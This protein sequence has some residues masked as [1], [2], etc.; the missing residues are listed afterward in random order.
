MFF[1][2]NK[3]RFQHNFLLSEIFFLG[4]IKHFFSFYI[5]LTDISSPMRIEI[6][7]TKN[8]THSFGDTAH[9][10]T[11]SVTFGSELTKIRV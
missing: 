4:Y 9:L 8:Y 6:I 10:C 11:I 3:V 5:D 1:D 2:K 7:E